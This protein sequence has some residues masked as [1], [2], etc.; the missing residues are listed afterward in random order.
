MRSAALRTPREI[1]EE[2]YLPTP[3][4][5]LCLRCSLPDCDESNPRC[6]LFGRIVPAWVRPFQRRARLRLY[7]QRER[8]RRRG[9]NADQA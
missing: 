6:L 7:K 1:P 5:L 8:A 4:D 3:A 2:E 9:E